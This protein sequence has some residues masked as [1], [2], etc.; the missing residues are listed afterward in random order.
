MIWK[1]HEDVARK[2]R[3]LKP[4]I[5]EWCH[6]DYPREAALPAAM[7]RR[8]VASIEPLPHSPYHPY[9]V[10][11]PLCYL[12][13]FAAKALLRSLLHAPNTWWTIYFRCPFVHCF[14][15]CCNTQR[16]RDREMQTVCK[17]VPVWAIY[18]LALLRGYQQW[19]QIKCKLPNRN[20]K[21][22]MI[23]N[24]FDKKYNRNS[25]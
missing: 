19:L 12:W 20:S 14:Q 9:P 21:W 25:W 15:G 16:K 18:L 5:G 4:K 11:V 1:H 6:L 2:C 13:I 23:G 3:S 8:L 10:A 24:K 22:P 17:D 7:C